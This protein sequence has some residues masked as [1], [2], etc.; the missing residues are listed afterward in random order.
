MSASACRLLNLLLLGALFAGS[1]MVY[2]RLPERFPVHFGLSGQPDGWAARSLLSWLALPL[3]AAS[4]ALLVEGAARLAARHPELWSVPDRARFLAL[5][6][7]ERAPIIHRLQRFVGLVGL[8]TT[9][10]LAMVQAAIYHAATGRTTALPAYVLPA[11]GIIM[12]VIVGMGLRM[13]ARVA[14]L[15]RDAH[16][17]RAA[18]S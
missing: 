16:H 15:I 3:I 17:R 5:T 4:A 7:E 1:L 14:T 10:L 13:N 8:M 12:A 11:A 6:P 18:A 2:S 9:L